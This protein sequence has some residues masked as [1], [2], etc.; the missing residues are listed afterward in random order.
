[1]AKERI[2]IMGAAGRDFHNFNLFFRDNESYEVVAF[3]ATQIPQIENRLY[4]PQLAGKLYPKG[5]SIHSEDD[6]VKLIRELKVDRVIFAYSDQSHINVMHKASIVTTAGADFTLM[7]FNRTSLKSSKPTIAVVAV[8]TGCG[9][10][11]TSRYIVRFFR[12]KGKKVGVIRHPMPYGDL[13]AQAVQ[14]FASLADLDKANCTIEERE[15][16]ESHIENG[17]T[18]YAGVDY[19]KILR[20]AETENDI[21]LWDGGNNDI[22]FIKPD[23]WITVADPLRPGHE[24]TYYPGESNLRGADAVVVNKVNNAKERDVKTVVDNI[25]SASPQAQIILADS[26]LH[27]ED[28]EKIKGKRVLV[29]EDGP[30]LTHG[31]MA[32]GAGKIAAEE[33]AAKEIIDPRPYAVGSLK[34]VFKSY[35]H[36]GAILPAMGYYPEQVAEFNETI[37]KSNAE[38]VIIGTPINLGKLLTINKPSVRVTYE[39]GD[40]EGFTLR[41]L[42]KKNFG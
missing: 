1:M 7:G 28:G 9:K 3:T 24:I 42:L 35:P 11:Q 19:E 5:I 20:L 10:S 25:K 31:D 14:R 27:V 29:V 22:P 36:I 17:T 15:E 13:A 38:L 23:L 30:T 16:Y 18:V 32:F 8:R 4:P 6:L 37:N 41:D 34:K 40:R 33:Y 39:L 2:L 26:K 21:I 12:E